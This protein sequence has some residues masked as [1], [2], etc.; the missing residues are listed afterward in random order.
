[1]T[2]KRSSRRQ[3]RQ[4]QWYNYLSGLGT[5][6]D[7]TLKTRFVRGQARTESELSSIYRHSWLARRVVDSLPHRAL[8][9]GVKDETPWP[10]NYA[11]L[12]YAN[13][14]W[15]EGAFLRAADFG[16]L[17]G[18]AGLYLGFDR[19][20][21]LT[22]PAPP[23]ATIAFADV[24]TRF[25]LQCAKSPNPQ[26]KNTPAGARERW[27]GQWRDENP[28]SSTFGQPLVWELI[29]QNPRTGLVFHS[30]RM[31]RFGGAARP[32]DPFAGV[33][34][35]ADSV[36]QPTDLDWSDSV[37]LS[38]WDDVQRYG[39]FW[40]NVDQLIS[41]ASVGWLKMRG[42]F[43]ALSTENS[44]DIRNRVDV[45][46]QALSSARLMMLD[47]DGNEEY[48]RTAVSFAGMGEMLQELQ[49]A[50]AG[51]VHMPVTELFGRAPA[52]MNAT[53]ESDLANWDSAVAGYQER[54]LGPRAS[55]YASA[56]AGRPTTIEFPPVRVPTAAQELEQRAASIAASHTLWQDQVISADEWRRALIEGVLPERLSG[57]PAAA[58]EPEEPAPEPNGDPAQA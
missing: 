22:Q 46:N 25:E 29:G 35:G 3:P 18:G 8:A 23:G 27:P 16:R 50:T 19:G 53:G 49:L 24:F 6:Q 26:A 34:G 5:S 7:R 28:N 40:Q 10:A 39:V 17:Y 38:V 56:L 37:L 52:G 31:I 43:D 45:M 4:D 2:S 44:Q 14:A 51:A 13:E 9:R 1:M 21:D 57:L 20:E 54:V 36:A 11:A 32:P 58:P 15:P 55:A 30:S 48:G 47:S 33:V 12:N 41:V 42:L